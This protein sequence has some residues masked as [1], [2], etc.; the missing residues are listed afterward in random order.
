MF[1]QQSLLRLAMDDDGEVRKLV[2]QG[3]VA[4]VQTVPE[5][6]EPNMAPIVQY[7]LERNQA[8]P[9]QCLLMS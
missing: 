8:S 7:V 1:P 3:L 5:R 6:L 2:C 9:Q 4:L